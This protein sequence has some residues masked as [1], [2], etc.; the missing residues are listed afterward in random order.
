MIP[1]F[2]FALAG[3]VMGL[4]L[5]MV[6]QHERMSPQA[7]VILVVCVAAVILSFTFGFKDLLGV[8]LP[9]GRWLG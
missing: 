9:D 1:I 4:G 6:A 7:L 2:G 8:P 3:L 5:I